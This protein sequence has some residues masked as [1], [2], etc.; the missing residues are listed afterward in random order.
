MQAEASPKTDHQPEQQTGPESGRSPL[1]SPGRNCWRIEHTRRFK[2]LIDADAYFSA[3]RAAIAQAQRSVFILGWDIDSRMLLTPAGADDGF[4]EAL[5]DFLHAVAAARP[6][7]HIHILNWDFAMLYALER[8]WLP[9]YKLGWRNQRRLSYCMDARHPVGA[10]HHQKVIV[11][12]DKLAFV[13]GLD[14]TRCRWDTPEHAA[15]HPLRYDPLGTPYPPFHDVQAMLDGDAAAALGELARIRWERAGGKSIK[16]SKPSKPSEAASKK[17]SANNLE[18]DIWPAAC[19]PDLSDFSIGIARTEPAYLGRSG[20]Y[21]IRQLYLDAIAHA[22]HFLFFENQYFTANVLSEALSARLNGEDAPEI[23]VIS[24]QLQSGWLEQATMGGLRARIHQRLKAAD[25]HG[26]YRMYCPH[27]P[28]L[29]DVCLNVH[30]KIFAV[31]DDMFCVGSANMSNRSM[32]FDTECNLIIEAQGGEAQQTRMR[33]AIAAM[34]NRLLAEHLNVAAETVAGTIAQYHSL[35]AA[36]AALQSEGRTMLPLDPAPLP[37]IDALAPELAVFDPERPIDADE[38]VAQFVPDEVRKPAPRRLIGLG[39]L[40]VMLAVIAL[41]WRFTPLHDW[42]NLASLIEAARSLDRQALPFTPLIVIL[43]FVV[44]ATFMVPVILLIAV[45]G[46]VFGPFYGA[47]YAMAGTMLTAAIGFALGVWL[48]RDTLRHMLGQR[49]NR[50][51]ERFAKRGIM[52]MTVLRLLPIAP[53]TVINVAAGASQ[54]RLRDYLIGT[55]LGMFPGIVLTVVFSH[56]LAQA[57]RHPNFA[58]ISVLVLL[59]LLLIALAFGLQRLLA[60]R[61]PIQSNGAGR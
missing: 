44:A 31:D 23:M 61:Q 30:S 32:A 13:G 56:N 59:A 9:V 45:S 54:L 25:R 19:E 39:A 21:E 11:I 43:A 55:M 60:P 10:S 14:L 57:V 37:E 46:V 1:L 33:K 7:L 49:V 26:R 35:H 24:P 2:L 6:H 41:A 36:V 12:D 5:G 16:R 4:P 20:V 3:A 18:H 29:N 17:E 27:L 53:F 15:E 52:A 48:G 58:T 51:N 50:F 47:L 38:L 42:I 34:R 8:E 40:A 28:D 22:R